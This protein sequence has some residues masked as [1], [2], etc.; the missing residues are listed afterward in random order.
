[1]CLWRKAGSE[2][3]AVILLGWVRRLQPIHLLVRIRLARIFGRTWLRAG[4]AVPGGLTS[5]AGGSPRVWVGEAWP[6]GA[7]L[8]PAPGWTAWRSAAL[9]AFAGTG[10]GGV[11]RCRAR[12]MGTFGARRGDEPLA[13]RLGPQPAQEPAGHAT[14]LAPALPSG[15]SSIGP[16]VVRAPGVAFRRFESALATIV[17]RASSR[18]QDAATA[19]IQV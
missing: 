3:L 16:I 15:M 14:G 18:D 17:P 7:G 6:L 1:M 4:A 12:R 9:P 2:R 13:E 19:T 11:Y 10:A 8:R 5:G